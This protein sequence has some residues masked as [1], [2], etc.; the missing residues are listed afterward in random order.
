M[1]SPLRLARG[2]VDADRVRAG[3]TGLTIAVGVAVVFLAA[4]LTNGIRTV[5]LTELELA[6]PNRFVVTLFDLSDLDSMSQWDDRPPWWDRRPVSREEARRVAEL[7][8]VRSAGLSVD[9]QLP[10]PQGGM[11]VARGGRSLSGVSGTGESAGWAERRGARFLQGRN[12]SEREAVRGDPVAVLG[13]RLAADLFG[14]EDPVG[15]RILLTTA[16][17]TTGAARVTPLR[18]V[19]VAELRRGILDDGTDRSLVVPFATATARLDAPARWSRLHVQPAAD[20]SPGAAEDQVVGLLRGL[21]RLE[22]AQDNDFALIWSEDLVGLV[23]RFT[24]TFLLAG[25]TLSTLTFLVGGAGVTGVMTLATVER[26][27]EI[28]VRRAVGATEGAILRQ[29]LAEAAALTL[30]GGMGGLVA[31]LGLGAAVALVTPLPLAPPLWAG[32]AALAMALATG[33]SAALL[34]AI[35]AARMDPVAALGSK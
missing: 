2:A 30:L 12:F 4:T 34:P 22:P 5:V 23:D 15:R 27:R 7:P 9:L 1:S 28:G 25:L 21:R 14:D 20:S 33:L 24:R 35:R 18:V 3:I 32:P 10:G 8:G 16:A 11:T 31:G 19:G 17:P 13:H 29:F 6:G 26:T